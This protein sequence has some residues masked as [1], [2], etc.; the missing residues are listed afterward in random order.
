MVFLFISIALMRNAM[1]ERDLIKDV[2]VAYQEN[3]V[4]IYESLMKEFEKDLDKWNAN[5]DNETLTFTFKSPDT[6]FD[7]GKMTIKPEYKNILQDF[8]QD[9]YKLFTNLKIL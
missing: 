4:S 9:I 8:F 2:A 1:V 6:L 7:D 5:I 3:Q